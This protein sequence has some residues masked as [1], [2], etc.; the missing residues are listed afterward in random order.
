MP[1]KGTLEAA[2]DPTRDFSLKSRGQFS[3][4]KLVTEEQ[5]SSIRSQRATENR[6]SEL[7]CCRESQNARETKRG[8]SR[9]GLCRRGQGVI[10]T[11]LLKNYAKKTDAACDGYFYVNLVRL[12]CP[13]VWSSTNLGVSV[14]IFRW[15]QLASAVS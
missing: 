14:K 3:R 10:R 6:T 2:L 9:M 12:K 5:S 11:R 8:P 4:D 7:K 13:V 1:D 15:S